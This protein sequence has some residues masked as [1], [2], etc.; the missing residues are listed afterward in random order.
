MDDDGDVSEE[1]VDSFLGLKS[2]VF[3]RGD[4]S[5]MSKVSSLETGTCFM[6]CPKLRR[7]HQSQTPVM[8]IIMTIAA[9]QRPAMRVVLDLCGIRRYVRKSARSVRENQRSINVR[10][11]A[12][13]SSGSCCCTLRKREKPLN[14][15]RL[16]GQRYEL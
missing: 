9:A 14:V 2:E 10:T 8:T 5:S 12:W 7:R 6:R 3:W 13:A 4:S 16:G 1:D 11:S 15:A